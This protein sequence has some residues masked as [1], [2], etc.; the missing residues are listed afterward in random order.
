MINTMKIGEV[1]RAFN[2]HFSTKFTLLSLSLPLLLFLFCFLQ[3]HLISSQTFKIYHYI[4]DV[5][6]W[7][8]GKGKSPRRFSFIVYELRL[9]SSL[10]CWMPLSWSFKLSP[11]LLLPLCHILFLSLYWW[12]FM[13]WLTSHFS[14]KYY[15]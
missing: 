11:M 14:L 12:S 6:G 15:M 5:L 4:K 9:R 1:A 10:D 7:V 3:F 13:P 8:E 2:Y